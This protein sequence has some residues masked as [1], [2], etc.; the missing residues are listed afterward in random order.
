MKTKTFIL[1]NLGDAW[2][3]LDQ[4]TK[5]DVYVIHGLMVEEIRVVEGE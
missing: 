1:R 3:P 2:E 5:Q 4:Q